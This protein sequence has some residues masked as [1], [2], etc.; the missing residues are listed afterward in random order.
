[1]GRVGR[2]SNIDYL[3][4]A[5]KAANPS[6]TGRVQRNGAVLVTTGR[7]GEMD[8]GS[9]L[10]QLAKATDAAATITI[11]ASTDTI[12][13][14]T[15]S[16]SL[17]TK[18]LT[19][20]TINGQIIRD[21]RLYRVT[22]KKT[23]LDNAAVTPIFRVTTPSGTNLGSGIYKINIDATAIARQSTDGDVGSFGQSLLNG[24]YHFVRAVAGDGGGAPVGVTSAVKVVSETAVATSKA[25]GSYPTLSTLV[26]TTAEIS[27]QVVEISAAISYSGVIANAADVIFDIE[28]T[29]NTFSSITIAAV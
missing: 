7:L 29:F 15:G 14:L 16:Q 18:T 10:L 9:N 17:S 13:N 1:M 28:L 11:P 2:T 26:I 24:I 23:G 25:D 21:T 6:V 4:F 27:E 8:S 5:D 19:S 12:V 22:I 3:Q 20:P